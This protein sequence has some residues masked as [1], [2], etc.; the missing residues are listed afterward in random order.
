MIGG[1][2]EEGV[3]FVPFGEVGVGFGF[4]GSEGAGD[5]AEDAG[6]LFGRGC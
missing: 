2:V 3:G 6:D 1:D 4:H 5:E